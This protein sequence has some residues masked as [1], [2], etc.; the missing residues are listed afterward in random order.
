M[1]AIGGVDI[2][3]WDVLAND[4][5]RPVHQL[6]GGACRERVLVYRSVAGLR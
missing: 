3:R 5:G 6:L 4:L 1:S 2:A